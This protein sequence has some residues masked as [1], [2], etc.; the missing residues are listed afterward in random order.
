[1][2]IAWELLL[3]LALILANG[4]FAAAEIAIITAR[5]SRLER[6]AAAGDRRS[7]L[8][9]E[10]ARDP[11]RFLSTVQVGITLVSTL[12]A[13]VGGAELVDYLATQIAPWGVLARTYSHA[14]ALGLVV[15][16]ITFFSLLLGELVPK[17]LALAGAERLAR[18]VAIPMYWL[19]W[20]GRPA[21][22]VLSVAC[23]GVLFFIRPSSA[24]EPTV[25][26]EDIEHMIKTGTIEGIL[27][28]EEQMVARR[29]L[30]LGDRTVREVMRPR[31][32]IDALD[33][34]TPP[35]EVLGAAAMAGFSR[36]PVHEGDLDH[37]I[38]FVY[39]KDLLRQQHM[40]WPMELRKLV[41][42]ALLVPETIPLD[43][44]LQ[45]FRE[46]R[47]QIAIVLDEFGGTE[48]LVTLEDV[49][50]ELVGEIHDEYRQD[51]SQDIVR[52]DARSWLVDANV[53]VDDFLAHAGLEELRT[54]SPREFST[55]GGLIIH[56][57]GRIP[58]IGDR[59]Q[60]QGLYLEVVDM[61]GP[62]IDRLLITT[63]QAK[64]K[65]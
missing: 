13:V 7:R 44:L 62:R 49:L 11:T 59:T 34:D 50:E 17:R 63:H 27:A 1:M 46:R 47:S 42:P 24:R 12:T 8:A 10:L 37:I 4:Y 38:G 20:A 55:V 22:W 18:A 33:I 48:G 14:L 23:D 53:S 41:R 15:L 54:T 57:L 56:A 60:W 9:A 6:Q 32:E 16:G 39:M 29:A 36:L 43:R 25:M 65:G 19:S 5:R 28:P 61:D 26:V 64:P 30:R 58:R 31:V 51:R 21:V 52:R 35:A 3:I 40:G 45:L 2:S